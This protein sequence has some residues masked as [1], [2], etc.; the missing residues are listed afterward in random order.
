MPNA[1]EGAV[2]DRYNLPL[3]DNT[4]QT[5]M[6]FFGVN[7][8][9]PRLGAYD[10]EADLMA[11]YGDRPLLPVQINRAP[12]GV[13]TARPGWEMA[14][15]HQ[16]TVVDAPQSIPTHDPG[17]MTDA[18]PSTRSPARL[19]MSAM[20][21]PSNPYQMR[22]SFDAPGYGMGVGSI[23]KGHPYQTVSMDRMPTNFRDPLANWGALAGTIGGW[24]FMVPPPMSTA[25]GAL[26]GGALGA[27]GDL[28]IGDI[29][30]DSRSRYAD[31][32]GEYRT[33]LRQTALEDME[34]ITPE[35]TQEIG[36]MLAGK[37]LEAQ[38]SPDMRR[39]MGGSMT[40]EASPSRELM[41]R[42]ANKGD[43]EL[44][45]RS[46]LPLEFSKRMEP[47]R[48]LTSPKRMRMNPAMTPKVADMVRSLGSRAQPEI[49]RPLHPQ[50]PYPQGHFKQDMLPQGP[51]QAINPYEGR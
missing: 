23:P 21:D 49:Y 7:R 41:N 32:S 40:M 35:Q 31:E 11:A 44:L 17:F 14:R 20:P 22:S 5:P 18:G 48:D 4:G 3:I 15:Y 42:M 28:A 47:P 34:N 24:E 36:A 6:E 37:I 25:I 45:E 38:A 19:P 51:F 9:V 29:F 50:G 16:G 13:D 30:G 12:F 10:P 39:D 8:L 46:N 1:L 2:R 26:G 27:A 33:E 43:I